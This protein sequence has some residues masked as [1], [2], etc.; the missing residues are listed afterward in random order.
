VFPVSNGSARS[1]HPASIP[2]G[3]PAPADGTRRVAEVVERWLT[4]HSPTLKVKTVATDAGLVRS[5][6]LPQL[7]SVRLASLRSSDVQGWINAMVAVCLLV[8]RIRQAH[9]VLAEALDW[10][11]RDGLLAVNLARAV[12]LPR[13]ERRERPSA[14]RSVPH[15]RRGG[16]LRSSH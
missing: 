6:I 15:P 10:A 2:R 16:R 4:L 13:L 12:E 7:G 8:S 14:R 11:V 1:G 9:V 3:E 5:R